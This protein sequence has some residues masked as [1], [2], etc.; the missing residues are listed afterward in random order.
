MAVAM[1][2]SAGVGYAAVSSLV[3]S[4]GGGSPGSPNAPAVRS[5]AAT[6][7]PAWLGVETMTFP[8][9][10]GVMVVDVVP[11]GPAAAA[12][13]Q[14]GDVITQIGNQA[15]QSPADLDSALAGMH[16]GQRVE[17]QYQEGPI[18]NT[19]QATLGARPANGP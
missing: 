8:L 13:L 5:P 19:T 11:G 9:A 4:R 10:N 2:L 15:V 14:P 17:I 12:G 3:G 1:L 16:A 18:N 7:A 6:S